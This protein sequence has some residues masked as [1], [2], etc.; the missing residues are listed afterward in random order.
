M[1]Q[2]R[3]FYIEWDSFSVMAIAGNSGSGKT[4][5]ARFMLCQ[6]LLTGV[7]II[8]A[9]P[10]GYIGTQSLTSSVK[11][12]EHLFLQPIAI[13]KSKRLELIRMAGKEFTLRKNNQKNSNRKFVLI[14]DE[15]T[16]HFLECTQEEI[17]E[18]QKILLSIANEARK[19]NMRIILIGQ[20]WRHD[21]IGSRSVR[22]SI[23][24]VI[25]HRISG[26]EVK[27]LVET[28]PASVRRDITQLAA[29]YACIYSTTNYFDVVKI[30]YISLDDIT[31]FARKI[32]SRYES[33]NENSGTESRTN[34]AMNHAHPDA[35]KPINTDYRD[36]DILLAKNAQK[37]ESRNDKLAQKIVLIRES[38]L[39]GATKE[40]TIK[41]VFNISKGSKYKPYLAAS[42]LYDRVLELMREQDEIM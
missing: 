3:P 6:L 21:F 42:K 41:Q 10:H 26:D 23:N 4:N 19:V 11:P 32:E 15:L 36:S 7:D 25:F 12:L 39:A 8:V 22:S 28:V 38:I 30:P 24:A 17:N 20:N 16:A 2:I 27:L 1:Q 40:N 5:T 31:L 13:E 35:V 14:I 18:Q 29:G 9:D 34:H 33:R 37:N